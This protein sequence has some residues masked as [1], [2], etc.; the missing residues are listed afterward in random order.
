MKKSNPWLGKT[1]VWST[2]V[3]KLNASFTLLVLLAVQTALLCHVGNL[4]IYTL[5]R[6]PT[7]PYIIAVLIYFH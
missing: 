2:G 3:K 6:L 1:V 7:I 4:N 5:I